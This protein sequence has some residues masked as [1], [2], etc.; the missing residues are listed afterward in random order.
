M[1]KDNYESW[2]SNIKS[3][4]SSEELLD[5]GLAPLIKLMNNENMWTLSSC[6]HKPCLIFFNV[7]N[8]DLF[9]EKTLPK[10]LKLNNEN[11][12][13]YYIVNKVYKH[14]NDNYFN[15][16]IQEKRDRYGNQ[17]CW[18]IRN[19]WAKANEFIE[20]LMKVFINK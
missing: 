17:Y 2:M 4:I 14:Y 12:Y 9:L 19:N 16:S 10:I 8:E 15:D 11:E 13:G 20:G 1:E 5:E 6:C 18:M 7:D 3:P